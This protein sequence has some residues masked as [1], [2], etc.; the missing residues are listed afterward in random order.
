MAA[1]CAPLREKVI[2]LQNT[3][4]DLKADEVGATGS[5]LHGIAGQIQR[6]QRALGV[7]TAELQTCEASDGK[8]ANGS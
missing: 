8:P 5:T 3:L 2:E 6:T 7:A 4:D 1:N